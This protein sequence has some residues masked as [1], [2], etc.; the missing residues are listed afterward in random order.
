MIQN[1]LDEVVDNNIFA[2][3]EEKYKLKIF[4]IE[5]YVRIDPDYGVEESLQGIRAIAGVTV[6]TAIDSTYRK[7]S[8]SYLSRIKIKYHPPGQQNAT[9]FVRDHILPSINGISIPGV[10]VVRILTQPERVQ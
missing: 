6:V 3:R 2:L 4:G 7:G 9:L 5:L 1:G 10:K 8:T